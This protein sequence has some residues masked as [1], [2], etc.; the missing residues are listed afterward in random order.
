MTTAHLHTTLACQS[1]ALQ[2]MAGQANLEAR[3]RQFTKGGETAQSLLGY[4]CDHPQVPQIGQSAQKN[5]D[6]A[7]IVLV[8]A[9]QAAIPADA[10]VKSMGE[11]RE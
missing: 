4:E 8:R 6:A 3:Q 9:I 5:C 7:H 11:S 10:M 2:L 1:A